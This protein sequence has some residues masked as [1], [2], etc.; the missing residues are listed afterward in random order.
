M[1]I[2][3]EIKRVQLTEEEFGALY[4]SMKVFDTLL[5]NIYRGESVICE[6]GSVISL[7]EID[8]TRDVISDVLVLNGD[9]IIG[10]PLTIKRGK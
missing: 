6:G 10:D 8:H 1:K 2:I 7:E 9:L 5:D 3:H 4:T